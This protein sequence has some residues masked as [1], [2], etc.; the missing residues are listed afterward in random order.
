MV[1]ENKFVVIFLWNEQ[2]IIIIDPEMNKYMKH[3][4]I[5]INEFESDVIDMVYDE[6]NK[7][8][9]I[10]LENGNYHEIDDVYE[11]IPNEFVVVPVVNGFMRRMMKEI[12]NKILPICLI[13]IIIEYSRCV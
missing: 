11:L 7:S 8:I 13:D 2:E 9:F 5:V 6:M 12:N 10:F 3:K 4:K 1:V